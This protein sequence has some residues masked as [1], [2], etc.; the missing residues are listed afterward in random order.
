MP[1]LQH[2]LATLVV[3]RLRPNPPTDDLPALREALVTRN[4]S[5][6][7]GPPAGVR[8]GHE[9]QISNGH[10]F[11]VFTLWKPGGRSGIQDTPRRSVFYVHG[12]AY[13]R[14]MATWHWRFAAKLADALE[15]QAVLPAYPVAPEYTVQD[16]FEEMVAA[17]QEVLATS[18]DG[19]VLAGDSAGGGY[20]LALA[21]AVRD[22]GGPQPTHLVLIAPWVDL[23]SSAPG[24]LEA[25][26]RDPWLSFEHL[27]IYAGFWAGSEDPEALADPRV[28][29]GLADL[30]GL[31]PA[32]MLCGTRDLL[33]PGCDALFERAEVADWS[34]EYVVAP[35]LIH[36][37]PLLPIPEARSAV[38]HIV[39]F[40][41]REI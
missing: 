11:S 1:S 31:P 27:S 41:T 29:P 13:V 18:P 7:E 22:R 24:T 37:Y 26:A 36:V 40:C 25:A 34:L 6:E 17:L 15:A 33:Q 28:S 19:V 32:L 10:G 35:G 38:E 16:S 21:Q 12:G 20:A 23:T 30:T 3:P 5:A 8:H 9:E 4:R 2:L 39:E 14:G